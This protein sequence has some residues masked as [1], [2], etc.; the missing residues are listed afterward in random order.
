MLGR[1]TFFGRA[2]CDALGQTL[3]PQ[4]YR[5]CRQRDAFE[6]A[7]IIQR[8]LYIRILEAPK[9]AKDQQPFEIA[10]VEQR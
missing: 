8:S 10:E 1:F 2:C 4:L 3:G 9:G 7:P 6:P 5:Q